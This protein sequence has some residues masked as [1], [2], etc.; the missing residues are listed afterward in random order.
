MSRH[1][2]SNRRS[3]REQMAE[4]RG[5]WRQTPLSRTI[6]QS[7]S[8]VRAGRMVRELGWVATVP[9][10]ST[11]RWAI[12]PLVMPLAMNSDNGLT[13]GGGPGNGLVVAPALSGEELRCLTRSECVG[14][15]VILPARGSPIGPDVVGPVIEDGAPSIRRLAGVDCTALVIA[16]IATLS[17]TLW[18]AHRQDPHP[19]VRVATRN[20]R[21]V[22]GPDGAGAERQEAGAWWGPP[23]AHVCHSGI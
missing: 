20:A 13:T 16:S 14:E 9:W 12:C 23:P 3:R 10:A 2:L 1:D 19:H 17:T 8:R 4:T 11:S 6:E 18:A 7:A 5:A 22:R 15:V 21:S